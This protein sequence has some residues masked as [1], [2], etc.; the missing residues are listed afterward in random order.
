MLKADL[1]EFLDRMPTD[2]QS[3]N[4]RDYGQLNT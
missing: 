4:R 3:V 1:I 2:E